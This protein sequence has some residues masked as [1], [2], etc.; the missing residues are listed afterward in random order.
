M[1]LLAL[2]VPI[3]L[4]IGC[5]DSS[6]KRA[7]ADDTAPDAGDDAGAEAAPTVDGGSHTSPVDAGAADVAH[8]DDATADVAVPS[9][10]LDPTF[11]AGGV[12]GGFGSAA[13]AGA[14]QPDGKIVMAGIDSGGAHFGDLGLVVRLNAD[15]SPD[16]A[17]GD[18]AQRQLAQGAIDAL[19][20]LPDGKL[21]VAGGLYA[22]GK[23]FVA[24]LTAD[25]RLDAAFGTGGAVADLFPT[26]PQGVRMAVRPDGKIVLFSTD[27]LNPTTFQLVRLTATG[28]IDPSFGNAGR[29]ALVAGTGIETGC[30]MTLQPDAKILAGAWT[31][32]R[33]TPDGAL[34]PSFGDGGRIH[35][36]Q[37]LLAIAVLPDGRIV[38]GGDTLNRYDATGKPDKTFGQ[39]GA[40]YINFVPN[41]PP[42]LYSV[43]GALVVQPD[44]KLAITGTVS[45]LETSSYGLGRLDVNGASDPTFGDAGVLNLV[46]GKYGDGNALLLQPDG[47]LVVVGGAFRALRYVP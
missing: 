44:G 18:A 24:R 37:E 42:S 14:L 35:A 39:D 2:A 23:G 27:G 22:P 33:L 47:K 6:D 7:E 19:A 17:F 5:S 41:G 9:R 25:G 4:L 16:T 29:V 31:G 34:D 15:G 1:R 45:D 8:D 21:L 13:N 11:G 3:A 40:Q 30:A 20:L 38:T 46:D 36:G 26:K 43:F 12:A 28:Q 32:V 10:G